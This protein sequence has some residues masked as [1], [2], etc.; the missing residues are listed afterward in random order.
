MTHIFHLGFLGRKA[1]QFGDTIT[2]TDGLPPPTE[3]E[4]ADSYDA[5]LEEWNKGQNP[6]KRWLDT[7]AFMSEFTLDEIGE[8]SLSTDPVIAALRFMLST[9]RSEVHADDSRVLLGI[10]SLV[11]LGILTEERKTQILS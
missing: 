10:N 6:P 11:G 3:E 8:I 4:L 5:A 1:N 9:W 7:E 2:F